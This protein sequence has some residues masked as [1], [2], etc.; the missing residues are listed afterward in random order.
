MRKAVLAIIL[1]ITGFCTNAQDTLT[2]KS[3]IVYRLKNVS[4]ILVSQSI[5]DS[6]L[7][8]PGTR[9]QPPSRQRVVSTYGDI[10]AIYVSTNKEPFQYTVNNISI[11]TGANDNIKIAIGDLEVGKRIL[12]EGKDTNWTN[13]QGFPLL[14]SSSISFRVIAVGILPVTKGD[15]YILFESMVGPYVTRIVSIRNKN[16]KEPLLSFRI[17]TIG[18]PVLPF[19]TSVARNDA[20]KR[21]IDSFVTVSAGMSK[22]SNVKIVKKGSGFVFEG[23]EKVSEE[24]M[25]L[26]HAGLNAISDL[27][28]YFR[29]Q[30]HMYPDSSMEYRLLSEANK[31]TSWIKTGHR[32]VVPHLVAGDYY[33]LQVRYELHPS[34]IQEHTFYVVPKW[35]QTTQTK[36][37]FISLPILITLLIWLLIYK[38]RLNKSKRRR[39]QLSLEIK[40]IRSQLNPHFIFNAL[41]SIQGLVN[42][43]DIPA[44]NLYLTEFSTLLRESLHNN[45]KEMVPLVTEMNLLETY[46]KLEQLR[47]DFKYEINIDQAI[48]KNATEIPNLILQPLVENAVKHGVSTLAGEGFIKI[49]FIK[50]EH[51]LFVLIADNGNKFDETQSTDGF[52]LKLTNNRISLLNQTIKEQP[53]QLIIER[54]QDMETIVHLVFKNWI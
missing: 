40:A 14:N 17:K 49:S 12:S 8:Q 41:S 29:K 24:S 34:Y 36:I 50:R 48:D 51:D 16:T 11:D 23:P 5:A 3:V 25:I 1:I 31:D 19:L 54:K 2:H 30:H 9:A 32:L 7:D 13:L 47:F 27:V 20:D 39:E 15:Y 38:Q 21:L 37:I 26:N 43:N 35:Y 42:K 18:K 10:L 45:D 22:V 33:K 44:A 28:F 53:I 4:I 52:G 46:L 6:L